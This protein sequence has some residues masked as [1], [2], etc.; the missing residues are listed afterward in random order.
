M[1]DT[2]HIVRAGMAGLA[3]ALALVREGR[4]VMVHEA[5]G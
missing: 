2:V 4:A 1:P 3:A 5:S